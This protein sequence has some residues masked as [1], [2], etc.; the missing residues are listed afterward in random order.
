MLSEVGLGALSSPH[1]Y[2]HLSLHHILQ[3]AIDGCSVC[4]I[5]VD[6]GSETWSL[7]QPTVF[8]TFLADEIT[9]KQT[10]SFGFDSIVG[11]F[12]WDDK[13]EKWLGPKARLKLGY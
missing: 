10:L 2:Q 9:Y 1:G 6:S 8:W 5:M 11:G 3:N 7:Y 4:Q 12:Q 13:F